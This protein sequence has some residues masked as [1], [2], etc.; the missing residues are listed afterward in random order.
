MTEVFNDWGGKILAAI[1]S[2]VVP[3]GIYMHRMA[4]RL[5][6]LERLFK[7]KKEM[8]DSVATMSASHEKRLSVIESVIVDLKALTP[9]LAN[10]AN[11]TTKVEILLENSS[12]RLDRL[13]EHLFTART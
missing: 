10:I 5:E 8:L 12:K 3:V 6:V 1:A 11:L 2:V 7:D 4:Y 13:E 9:A